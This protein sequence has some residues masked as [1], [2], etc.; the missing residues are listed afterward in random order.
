MTMDRVRRFPRTVAKN[1][2]GREIERGFICR[3]NRE[4]GERGGGG[5]KGFNKGRRPL[6]PRGAGGVFILR[7]WLD[8][9][10]VAAG[11]RAVSTPRS[12]V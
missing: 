5:G 12:A 4:N 9:Y 3:A 2:S 10:F 7:Q 11:K 1:P 6:S 8:I